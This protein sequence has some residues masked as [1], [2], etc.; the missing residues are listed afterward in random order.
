ML[1]SMRVRTLLVICLVALAHAAAYIVHQRPDWGVSWTDQAGYQRLGEVL[2]STG[3]FTRYPDAVT[4]VPEVIRTP[5]YPAFVAVIYRLFGIGNQIAVVACQA[6]VFALLC[7]LVFAVARR[8]ASERVALVAALM[9]ALFPP[10][11]YFGALVVTELWTAFL[12][13]LA[14]LA[15]LRAVQTKRAWTYAAAGCLFSLT[16]LVRPAFFLLPFFL[17]VGVPVLVRQQRDRAALKGWGALVLAAGLTLAPWFAYNYVNLGQ[18]TISPAGGVGRGIW[19]VSWQGKWAGRTQA[20]L[21]AAA[22]EATDPGDLESRARAIARDSGNDPEPMVTYVR[23]WRE[24]HDLWDRPQDPVERARARI[25]ADQAYFDAGMKH[26]REDPAGYVRRALTRSPVILWVAEIPIRYSLINSV[27]PVL[28][29]GLWLAQALLMALALAGFVALARGGR[30]LESVVLGLPIVY[31]TAV[32][33]PL[34][35]E[36]RQSL[37]AKP[38]V[39]VLAAVGAMMLLGRRQGPDATRHA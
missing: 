35:C 34:F 19:E 14:M 1:G 36:A 7:L 12:A 38:I 33:I 28:I 4:F 15:C 9:T 8:V 16:A 39:L 30:W 11:P 5:G 22:T 10:L 25:A 27:P 29:R 24:I 26:L 2:A 32:H 13:T 21:T 6:V 23:E 20:A 31:V 3:K 18:L 17:A 37:P